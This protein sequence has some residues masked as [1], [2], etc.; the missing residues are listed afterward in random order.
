[1]RL[2]QKFDSARLNLKTR[3]VMKLAVF[4]DTSPLAHFYNDH[5][6][7]ISRIVD[8][9]IE[10][11]KL[12]KSIELTSQTLDANQCFD[13]RSHLILATCLDDLDR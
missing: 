1:M 9:W 4:S 2:D 8:W 13:D 11:W 7:K 10:I 6:I 12:W 3:F 5:P